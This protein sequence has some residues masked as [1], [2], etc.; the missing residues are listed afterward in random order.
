LAK[1]D[2]DAYEVASLIPWSIVDFEGWDG[3]PL[4]QKFFA[5]GEAFSHLKYL[6]EKGRVQKEMRGE[7]IV[8]SPASR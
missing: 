2:K 5:T 3:V 1:G 8:Y 6:E 7:R 4:L